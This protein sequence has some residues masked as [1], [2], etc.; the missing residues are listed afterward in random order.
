MR[1][2]FAGV[3]E[4]DVALRFFGGIFEVRP[5]K[6]KTAVKESG[7]VPTIDRRRKGAVKA[8]RRVTRTIWRSEKTREVREYGVPKSESPKGTT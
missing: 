4:A 1:S 8:R 6:T 2:F 7:G 3:E 5:Q